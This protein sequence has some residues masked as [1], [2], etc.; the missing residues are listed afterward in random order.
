[1]K[2]V[3]SDET[4]VAAFVLKRSDALFAQLHQRYH[5]KVFQSCLQ[6][7]TDPEEALDQTQE[8]F[9]KVYTRLHTFRAE[10]KFSTWLFVLT[11]HHC[12]TVLDS[13]K[14]RPFVPL[15]VSNEALGLY[16]QP[17][18]PTLDERWFRAER[19]LGKLSSQ[20]QQLLRRRYLA[21]KDVATLANEADVSVSAM[22]MRLKRAR[23]QAKAYQ[24][25][26]P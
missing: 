23:D 24:Q 13:L 6:L 21:N 9:C 16:V 3:D 1:M 11:R 10:A 8:I 5:Q 19:S 7:L 25:K 4:I 15:D 14:R 18:E 2:Q 22:K 17:E 26:C 12:L 20:D